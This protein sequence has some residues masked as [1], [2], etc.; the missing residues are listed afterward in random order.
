M[1][2]H[3]CR[4]GA[5][6]RRPVWGGRLVLGNVPGRFLTGSSFTLWHKE[7]VA[8]RLLPT[9]RDGGGWEGGVPPPSTC[10]FQR[11][12]PRPAE[13][14]L[15]IK[16]AQRLSS[17]QKNVCLSTKK[18]NPASGVRQRKFSEEEGRR[19]LQGES[20]PCTT[21]PSPG[22]SPAWSEGRAGSRVHCAVAPPLVVPVSRGAVGQ[23]R[24]APTYPHGAGAEPA[25][26]VLRCLAATGC[27]VDRSLRLCASPGDSG[28]NSKVHVRLTSVI[29]TLPP[30]KPAGTEDRMGA[31]C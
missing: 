26:T 9:S 11:T 4:C 30:K 15:V 29:L 13:R 19:G 7:L 25:R 3:S 2:A 14:S 6:P 12:A 5:R 16:R 21:S 8:V 20:A 10:P 1:S 18:E 22:L 31:R 27:R 28:A 24:A 23:R 17:L